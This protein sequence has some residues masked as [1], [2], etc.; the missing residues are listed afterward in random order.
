MGPAQSTVINQS[1]RRLC[2]ITFNNGDLL[3]KNYHSMY[4]LEPGQEGIVEA[5]P[6]AV[7]LK[8]GVVYDT[9]NLSL[10]HI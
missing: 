3:Y 4:V 2:I 9:N 1:S 5:N 7:G 10:I 6:D 8:I